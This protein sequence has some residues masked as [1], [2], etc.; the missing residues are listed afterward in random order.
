MSEELVGR[1]HGFRASL[2]AGFEPGAE[3]GG[4][5][6]IGDLEEVLING[7]EMQ[8]AVQ[9]LELA[10]LGHIGRLEEPGC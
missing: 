3:E 5:A 1:L 6:D 8:R 10:T 2:T 9:A 4:T 7:R